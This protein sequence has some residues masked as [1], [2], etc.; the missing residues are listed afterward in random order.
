MRAASPL[1]YRPADVLA[2]F[3]LLET[4]APAPRFPLLIRLLD[5]VIGASL[6]CSATALHLLSL[7]DVMP[8]PAWFDPP[9][10]PG[11]PAA[12]S[13][14]ALVSRAWRDHDFA[15]EGRGIN[16]FTVLESLDEPPLRS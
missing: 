7:E 8:L 13:M 6:A 3:S 16:H 2:A 12:R 15:S 11:E 14:L 5:G 9:P 1:T 10:G 4:E